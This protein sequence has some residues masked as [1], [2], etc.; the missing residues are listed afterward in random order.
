MKGLIAFPS[1]GIETL[2]G[3][4]LKEVERAPL[5]F[6]LSEHFSLVGW[7]RTVRKVSY[8]KLTEDLLFFSFFKTALQDRTNRL[9]VCCWLSSRMLG[10]GKKKSG[11]VK[12]NS[13]ETCPG[14]IPGLF[15]QSSAFKIFWQI[16]AGIRIRVDRFCALILI[17]GFATGE[18]VE[19]KYW[20]RLLSMNIFKRS[21]W[22]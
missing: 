21:K 10:H 2:R 4:K 13:E 22:N 6:I 19:Q 18:M 15:V 12:K 14:R 1:V 17:L 16:L 5:L 20:N 3:K 11:K 7:S 8:W 9:R